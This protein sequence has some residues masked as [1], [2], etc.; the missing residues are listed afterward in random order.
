M[1]PNWEAIGAIGELIGALAVVLT[2]IYL[3]L[4]LRRN[5]Q[6]VHANTHQ[7]ILNAQQPLW[8]EQTRFAYAEQILSTV[9]KESLSP[10]EAL[11]AGSHAVL[12]CRAHQNIFNQVKSGALEGEAANLDQLGRN[13]AINPVVQR[14]WGEDAPDIWTGVKLIDLLSPDYVNY[15]D[16]I[17]EDLLDDA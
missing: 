10:S 13:V 17:L 7:Q 12:R 5:T 4:Q 8:L 1:N 2:L 15:L 6:S 14:F 16:S 3:T 11:A 9:A